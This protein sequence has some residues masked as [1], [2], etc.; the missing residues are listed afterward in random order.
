MPYSI[1][2]YTGTGAQTTFTVSFPFISRDHVTV[3]VAGT[4]VTPEWLNDGLILLS[5]APANGALVSIARNSSRSAKLVDFQDAQVLTEAAL[6][7]ANTQAI[8]ISQEAFDASDVSNVTSGVAAD[9]AAAAASAA[10]A[11]TSA[12]NSA[13]S[14]AGS[15]TSA[16]TAA[17]SA[18]S[19]AGSASSALT[20]AINAAISEANAAATLANALVKTNNLSDLTDT[21]AARSNLGLGSAALASSASF[22]TVANNLFDLANAAT[23]RTNLGL[24]TAAVAASTAFATAAQGTLADSAVQ[25]VGDTMTGNLILTRTASLDRFT[26]WR[27]SIAN[28]NGGRWAW[29]H[30]K[31]G[32][33]DLL[34]LMPV[35]DAGTDTTAMIKF[36]RTG[37]SP[38]NIIVAA[39]TCFGG[40][41]DDTVSD[42]QCYALNIGGS[43]TGNFDITL[44]AGYFITFG[45]GGGVLNPPEFDDGTSGTTKTIT[46]NGAS[47]FHKVSMTGNCTFTLTFPFA[48]KTGVYHLKLTQ[49][50]TGSRVMTLP[51]GKW[52]ARYAAADKLLSTAANAID[53]LVVKNDGTTLWYQLDKAWA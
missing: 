50:A 12:T 48:S 47:E 52:P 14:A 7:L 18:T 5:P 44:P 29:L 3:T 6:D 43:L 41:A 39:R 34:S 40:V 28:T 24:G 15:A 8:Y 11:A 26:E 22:L 21:T 46:F 2:Q 1:V 42:L 49:D 32:A 51:A 31:S 45:A 30:T 36:Q 16:T 23:A 35:T 25:R 53:L 20:S 13:T 17:T 38:K 37:S 19:A 10:A 33:D 27:N 9:A 4:P